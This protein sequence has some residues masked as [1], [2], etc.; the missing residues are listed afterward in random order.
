MVTKRRDLLYRK[1]STT[2]SSVLLTT[3][4]AA[5]GIDI[6]DI[7]LV[8]QFDPPQDPAQFSHR[9]GRTARNGKSG[10]AIV[11]IMDNEDTFIEFLKIRHIPITEYEP[12]H[13][14][15][16]VGNE[17]TQSSESLYHFIRNLNK[18]DREHYDKVE[19]DNHRAY[20]PL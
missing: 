12:E 8:I 7:E 1:F 19:I 16:I 5:R 3:D 10:T 20:R 13:D 11:M 17:F 9:C 15:T 18:Q 14:K 4:V 2:P 6:P